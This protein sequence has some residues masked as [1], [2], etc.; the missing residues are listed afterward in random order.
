[1]IAPHLIALHEWRWERLRLEVICPGCEE[2]CG[3]L[4]GLDVLRGLADLHCVCGVRVPVELVGWLGAM[5]PVAPT[6]A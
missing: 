6:R 4:L 1:V 5:P 2:W 3:T